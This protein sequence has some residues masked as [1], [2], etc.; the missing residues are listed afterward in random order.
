MEEIET[1]KTLENHEQRIVSVEHRIKNLETMQQS[2][3][4]LIISVNKLAYN[5][6]GMLVEQKEQ[7]ERL[8]MLEN[9]PADKW[10]TMQKTAITTI[11]GVVAGAIATGILF[12]ISH[13]L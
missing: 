2:M 1:V 4:D 12:T 11:I 6:E 9:E 10:K 5:M 13:Y 7:G 3:N 8:K